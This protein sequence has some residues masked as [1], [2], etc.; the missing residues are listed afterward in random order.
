MQPT[1]PITQ[2]YLEEVDQNFTQLE[3]IPVQ[4]L[5]MPSRNILAL[6]PVGSTAKR[7]FQVD[8]DAL[9][10]LSRFAGV[11]VKYVNSIDD[12]ALA[13]AN[14]NYW[15]R[16]RSENADITALK[17]VAKGD[18]IETFTFAS[19]QPV[20]PSA[21]V[22]AVQG[23]IADAV[24]ERQPHLT[25][26]DF[27]FALTGPDLYENFLAGIEQAGLGNVVDTN[28]ISGDVHHF[29]VAVKYNF[30]GDQSPEIRVL[31]H[32]HNCGNIIESPYGI[33]G[34]QFRIFTTNPEQIVQK[35]DE[36]S[37]KGVEFIRQTMIPHTR[38]LMETRL[39]DPVA[40]LNELMAKHNVPE[41]VQE[42]VFEAYRTENLGGT[43]YHAVNALTRAANSD[44][45]PP[46]MVRRL[47]QLG[48][49]IT[50]Q[51]DPSHPQHRCPTCHQKVQEARARALRLEEGSGSGSN[52]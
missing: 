8:A 13:V 51:H 34:K 36:F 1:K 31:G 2:A 33:G 22:R 42:L 41:R 6:T 26:R 5:E 4:G 49:Q 7:E 12:D 23:S 37:R 40:D 30:M 3:F 16:K 47:H 24:F 15:L 11:P 50:V 29:S 19:F 10:W 25:K 35:F 44:R 20:A 46:D 18:S 48:G 28:M 45:C 14:W 27:D 52:E 43:M 17:A 9:A 38:A 39:Q 21:I 32:R